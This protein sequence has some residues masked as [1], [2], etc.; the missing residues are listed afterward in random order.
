M[1]HNLE[2]Q[3]R[4]SNLEILITILLTLKADLQGMIV[5][6]DLHQSY[7]VNLSTA[8]VQLYKAI[9]IWSMD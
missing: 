9:H 4:S 7:R 2:I 3:I 8:D 6:C 1:Q 5:V